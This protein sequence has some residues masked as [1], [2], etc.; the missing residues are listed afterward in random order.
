MFRNAANN[1][2]E[3]LGGLQGG[4]PWKF[5]ANPLTQQAAITTNWK[6]KSQMLYTENQK[7]KDEQRTALIT[8]S[9]P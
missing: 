4:F 7:P 2:I 6:N 9:Q 8:N 1:V 5:V 3:N